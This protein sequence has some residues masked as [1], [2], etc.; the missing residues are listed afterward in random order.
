MFEM[1]KLE[2]G[3]FLGVRVAGDKIVVSSRDVARVFDRDH[4]DVLKSIRNL[5]CSQSFNERNFA[6]VEYRDTKGESRPE[7]LMSR[8]GFTL[9]VMGYNG[10]RAMTFKEAYIEEFGRM[11]QTLQG[12][13]LHDRFDIP[14]NLVDALQLA[15]DLARKQM[16]AERRVRVLTPKA[17][18]W[19]AT[20]Q[21]GTDMSLQAVGKEFERLGMG[22]RKIFDFLSKHRVLYRLDGSWVPYQEHQDTGRFRV[23][24]VNILLHGEPKTVMKTLVTPKGRDF[25]AGLIAQTRGGLAYAGGVGNTGMAR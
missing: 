25:I 11:E 6:P 8:D 18:A 15:A 23:K 1:A 21:E 19:D 4:K 5:G 14:D 20:C 7:F 13:K 9:L 3:G 17:E 16:E 22:P 2:E 24:R 12:K 10:E